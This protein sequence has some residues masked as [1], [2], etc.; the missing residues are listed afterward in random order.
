VGT[1]VSRAWH[2]CSEHEQ[3]SGEQPVACGLSPVLFTLAVAL[4]VAGEFFDLLFRW[5][6]LVVDARGRAVGTGLTGMA[7]LGTCSRQ[8][9]PLLGCQLFMLQLASRSEAR[10]SNHMVPINRSPDRLDEHKQQRDAGP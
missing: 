3:A 9:E 4:A 2:S 1:Y 7:G 5:L 6:V 10:T 8:Q